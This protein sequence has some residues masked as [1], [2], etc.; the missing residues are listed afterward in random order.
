MPARGPM[1]SGALVP[2]RDPGRNRGRGT[3]GK[4]LC[5]A[6]GGRTSV[7]ARAPA[8]RSAGRIGDLLDSP[9]QRIPILGTRSSAARCVA[10][11]DALVGTPR[12]SC[13]S[14]RIGSTGCSTMAK[15]ALGCVALSQI[16]RGGEDGRRG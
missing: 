6:H 4:S 10:G 5:L 9:V 7:L 8:I 2:Q 12:L 14:S 13:L 11:V 1:R 3:G 16:L 15:A